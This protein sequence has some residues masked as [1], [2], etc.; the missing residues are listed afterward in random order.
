V[1]VQSVLELPEL[2]TQ[3]TPAPIKFSADLCVSGVASSCI[4]EYPDP[5]AEVSA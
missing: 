1:I 5:E 3:V 4:V 2:S